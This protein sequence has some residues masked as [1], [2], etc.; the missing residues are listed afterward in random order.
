MC[1]AALAWRAHPRW[2]LVIA[3]N[4]DEFQDRPA[5]PLAPWPEEAIWAG[6]D[7]P[8]Q[9]TWLGVHTDN[10]AI[11]VTNFRVEGFPKPDRPSRGGLV[12]SLLV[13]ESAQTFPVKAYN[14]FNLLHIGPSETSHQRQATFLTNYPHEE[15][16]TL[17]PGLH[18]LSNGPR[19]P[20]WPKTQR[21]ISALD[22]WLLRNSDDFSPLFTALHDDSTIPPLENSPTNAPESRLSSVFIRDPNYGTRCS[23]VLAVD[24]QGHGR[25]AE[26]RFDA[27]GN[28]TGEEAFTFEWLN[29]TRA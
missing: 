25:I 20:P 8:S 18:G 3:T 13:G 4:R 23:T 5:L 10:R 29:D 28:V 16:I 19:I 12:T 17:S 22:A 9:G 2:E 26:T 6:R 24:T 14:P 7:I 1:I 21:L 11:L 15:R 27:N